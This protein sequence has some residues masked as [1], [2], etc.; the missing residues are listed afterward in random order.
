MHR[1]ESLAH[2]ALQGGTWR[3][4]YSC[5]ANWR[6]GSS[7]TPSLSSRQLP[8]HNSA[9]PHLITPHVR[10]DVPTVRNQTE[11]TGLLLSDRHIDRGVDA[12]GLHCAALLTDRAGIIRARCA[13]GS[14]RAR[15]VYNTP[16]KQEQEK[17][18]VSVRHFC[19]V[20]R[21]SEHIHDNLHLPSHF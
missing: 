15:C 17:E 13:G 9:T 2:T 4:R 7:K 18:E 21:G 10:G 1:R 19:K 3:W 11:R 5:F 6:F 20:S 12:P 14:M 8:K 16:H